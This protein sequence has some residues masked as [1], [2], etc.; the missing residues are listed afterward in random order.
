MNTSLE[1]MPCFM[2][3]A[4][5]EARLACPDNEAMHHEI[6]M[7]WGRKLSELDFSVP[8]PAIAR[9]LADLIEK[10]TGAGDLYVNDKREANERVLS[11]L[12]DLKVLLSKE[13][14]RE[15]GDPLAL[16]LE[17]AIIGNYIF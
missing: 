10:K 1:C 5:R 13:R 8:P 3:M 6:V 16:A 15:G 7:A 2:K 12:P 9:H 11:L 14:Q 17:L 4:I